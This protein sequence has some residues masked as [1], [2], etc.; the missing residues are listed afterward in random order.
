MAIGQGQA[1]KNNVFSHQVRPILEDG[2][3]KI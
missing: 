2:T 3:L 1:K